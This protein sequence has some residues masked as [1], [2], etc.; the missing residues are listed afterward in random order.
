MRATRRGRYS[1]RVRRSADD[2]P[3]TVAELARQ[4]GVARS[5]LR[6]WAKHPDRPLQ[7]VGG[8]RALHTWAQLFDFCDA[9]PNLYKSREILRRR[10]TTPAARA[11]GRA[12]T[13]G[14]VRA[15]ADAHLNAVVEA[16]RAA[17]A[18]A[19]AHREQLEGLLSAYDDAIANRAA[20]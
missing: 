5:T 6:G 2:E 1:L 8:P 19:R 4:S 10:T 18:V 13:V 9:H 15:L 14:D 3:L 7:T 16:V 12:A 11:A 17:E 20:P